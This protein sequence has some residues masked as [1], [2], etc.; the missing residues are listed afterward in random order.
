MDVPLSIDTR[1]AN[2]GVDETPGGWP[3]REFV[4]SLIWLSS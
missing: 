2:F 4:G 3:F 1:L